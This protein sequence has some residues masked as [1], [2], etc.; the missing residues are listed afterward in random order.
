MIKS[1]NQIRQIFQT[2]APRYIGIFVFMLVYKFEFFSYR[3]CID[4]LH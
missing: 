4:V 3:N 1:R 2:D